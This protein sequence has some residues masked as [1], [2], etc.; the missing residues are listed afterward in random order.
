MG[1]FI[2]GGKG[3]GGGGGGGASATVLGEPEEL[4][5][6]DLAAATA[7]TYVFVT[8]DASARVILPAD[9][10]IAY[11]VID[12]GSE[13]SGEP[14]VGTTHW[15]PISQFNAL[16]AAAA[17]SATNQVTTSDFFR[18]SATGSFTRRDFSWGLTA[19]RELVFTSDSAAEG[20]TGGS[21]SIVRK[22]A[23]G[24]GG[25]GGGGGGDGD[26]GYIDPKDEYDADDLGKRVWGERYPQGRPS[27]HA[28]WSFTGCRI[29]EPCQ[30]CVR[31]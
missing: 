9:A 26:S 5:S 30:C 28:G 4:W 17:V 16:T 23:V 31:A 15:V 3:G 25:G 27:F 29:P 7:D 20:I 6:G 19:L 8:D 11:V 21:V 13:D 24:G 18:G 10:D 22:V 14:P 2:P 1:T 12:H